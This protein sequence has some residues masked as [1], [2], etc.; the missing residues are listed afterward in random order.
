[1]VL[2]R[3]FVEVVRLFVEDVLDRCVAVLKVVMIFLIVR[4]YMQSRLVTALMSLEFR[5]P[6]K[7]PMVAYFLMRLI[8]RLG[9]VFIVMMSCFIVVVFNW[10]PMGC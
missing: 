1:M 7:C 4:L 10:N 3:F 9:L 2:E 5:Y 6:V 8:Q